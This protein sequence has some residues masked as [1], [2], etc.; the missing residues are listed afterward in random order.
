MVPQWTDLVRPTELGS[1]PSEVEDQ[2]SDRWPRSRPSRSKVSTGSA[3]SASRDRDDLVERDAADQGAE[4]GG[5]RIQI[6]FK[7]RSATDASFAE[8]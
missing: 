3:T 7:G 4:D 6:P 1:V 8:T 2:P 5:R